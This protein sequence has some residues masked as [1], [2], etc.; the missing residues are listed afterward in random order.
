MK[1]G[2]PHMGWM[3][4][5]NFTLNLEIPCFNLV[6]NL[7]FASNHSLMFGDIIIVIYFG[8]TDTSWS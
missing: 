8:K 3:D 1:T 7:A 5:Y 2:G 6:N 4:V